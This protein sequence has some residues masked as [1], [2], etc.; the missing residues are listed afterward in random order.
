MNAPRTIAAAAVA[1]LLG[2]APL[3]AKLEIEKKPLKEI[4]KVAILTM[5]V[6]NIGQANPIESN[7][8]FL[9]DAVAYG[10]QVYTDNLKA[11][12]KWELVPTPDISGLEALV[13]DLPASPITQEV[14]NKLADKDKLPGEV[15]K[16]VMME[17]AMAAMMGKKD[18]VNQMKPKLI[19]DAARQLQA[20]MDSIRGEMV[21]EPSTAGLPY[22]MMRAEKAG[23][24]LNGALYSILEKAVGDYCAANGLDGVIFVQM[25]SEAGDRSKADISVIVQNDRV[26]STLKLNPAFVLRSKDGKN[27]INNG[28][29]RLD[30]L[31]PMKLGV[32]IY[33]GDRIQNQVVVE[34]QKLDLSDPLGKAYKAY[35]ELIKDTSDDLMKDLGKKLPK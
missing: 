25:K 6:D 3:F 10:L 12:G 21:W 29:P 27:A 23:D 2:T 7:Q 35:Q 34:R 15:D 11:L 14:L 22:W 26:I 8:K 30:D 9:Q 24:G 32:P 20:H 1:V 16:K 4:K 33:K 18:K 28:T 17:L 5:A 31:A 13:K 19:A